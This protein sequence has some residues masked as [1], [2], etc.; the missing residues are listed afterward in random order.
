MVENV[1]KDDDS[2]YSALQ[3][4]LDFTLESGHLCHLSEIQIY[5]GD[6]GPAHI[7]VYFSNVEGGWTLLKEFIVGRERPAKLELSGELKCKFLR[8]K[9]LQNTR[10]GNISAT[11]Y[12]KV[13]GA[14]A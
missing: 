6:V 2:V 8:L 1:L 13:L 7:E 11:R 10:G 5:P 12:I 14:L 9:F 3:P 4:S